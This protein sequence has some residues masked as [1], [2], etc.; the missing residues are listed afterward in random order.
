MKLK[1][2]KSEID[3]S[4]FPPPS[5][6]LTHR[7]LVCA[8]LAEGKSKIVSPLL[9]DDT[10]A[11]CET[12]TRL[13]VTI[14]GDREDYW[15][16]QGGRLEETSEYLFCRESGTT[17]RFM[18]AVCA[19]I[20]GRSVLTSRPHLSRRPIQ[21]LLDALRELGAECTKTGDLGPIVI[22]GGLKGGYA[23][24]PG[25]VSSQFLSALL[26]ASPL[27][28]NP[29]DLSLKTPLKSAPYVA[30]TI[31][32]QRSFGV[33]VESSEGMDHFR[34]SGE[35]YAPSTIEVERDWSSAAYLLALGALAGR[36]TVHGMKM[37]SLQ[38]DTRIVE[39]L[40]RMGA[41]VATQADRVSVERSRLSSIDYDVS[42]CPDIFPA[43]S[44]LCA[45]AEG[46]SEIAGV[47]RLRMKESDRLAE[48]SC[49]LLKAGVKVDLEGD[50]L[51]IEGTKPKGVLLH[52]GNDHRIAMAYALLGLA[53]GGTILENAD[54]VCK[55]YPRFWTDLKTVGASLERIA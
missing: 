40:Q 2:E 34:V 46:V 10:E 23:T 31:E 38:A 1:L 50:R 15:Q 9:C 30:M 3:G 33:D 17:L 21:P 4:I 54:C 52:C 42:D 7:A 48:M 45:F 44:V 29:V 19:T 43:L 49:G 12:L 27:A 26:L 8:G 28:E 24:L 53:T 55:S 18:T 14:V 22:H 16:V 35:E 39:I 5:K 13:G 47:S 20:R 11:T 51:L 37:K 36:L 32:V 25:D 41:D 6:S